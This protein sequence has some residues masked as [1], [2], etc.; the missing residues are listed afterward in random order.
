MVGAPLPLAAESPRSLTDLELASSA[1]LGNADA[2]N[3]ILRRHWSGVVSYLG[4]FVEDR[5]SALDVAQD[6]FLAFWRGD[7]TWKERGSIRGFLYG[8][9]RNLAHNDGRRWREVRGLS[10][11]QFD[12]GMGRPVETPMEALEG[13]EIRRRV[14]AAVAELPPR[15]QETF[16]LARVHGL[17]HTEIA[18]ALGVST[19]TVANQISAALTELRARLSD[20]LE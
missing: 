6:T 16:I 18:Q 19:Q 1:R 5:D 12:Q 7:V 9:A 14:A 17:S 13:K 20:L 8:V 2:M 10:L 4:R 3:E 11:V 15:R